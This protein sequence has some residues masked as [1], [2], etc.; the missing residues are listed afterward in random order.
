M[1]IGL[2]EGAVRTEVERLH[3]VFA[4]LGIPVADDERVG[5]T[6]RPSIEP[7]SLAC[8]SASGDPLGAGERAESRGYP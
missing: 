7:W 2:K 6:F 1:N 5:K 3:A 4:S 8:L